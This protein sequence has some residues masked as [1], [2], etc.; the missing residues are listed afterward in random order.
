MPTPTAMAAIVAVTMLMVSPAT[1]RSQSPARPSQR[2][3]AVAG[4]RIRIAREDSDAFVEIEGDPV[5]ARFGGSDDV[6]HVAYF[7]GHAG[8]GQCVAADLAQGAFAPAGDAGLELGDE[9]RG[10]IGQRVEGGAQG[11]THSI[12]CEQK[13]SAHKVKPQGA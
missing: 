10:V 6:S 13:G 1:P 4:V 9:Y 12:F 11:E 2:R 7:E 8:V 3:A 5:E